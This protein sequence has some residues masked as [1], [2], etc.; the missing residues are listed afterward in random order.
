MKLL[1]KIFLPASLFLFSLSCEESFSPIGDF[2]EKYTLNC[3][4]NGNSGFQEATLTAT[5]FADGK[6]PFTN[7]T[8]PVVKDAIIKIWLNP[9][10][11][12]IMKDST[13][14]DTSLNRYNTPKYFYYIENFKPDFDQ[15]L[16]IEAQLATGQ[17][18]IGTTSTPKQVEFNRRSDSMLPMDNKD[19]VELSWIA[20]EADLYYY[21][22]L[23]FSYEKEIN[24]IR[25]EHVEKI[26]A[27]FI[28]FEGKTIPFYPRASESPAVIFERSAII[29]VLT[30]ISEGIDK[31]SIYLNVQAE[32]EVTVL[33]KNLKSYYQASIDGLDQFTVRLDGSDFTNISGGLGVFG[34]YLKI[35]RTIP[36]S[37]K[38]ITSLGYNAI[39]N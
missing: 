27:R 11:V 16:R 17:R 2:E 39:F 37:E 33:D 28:E 19:I 30:D 32:L 23:T 29:K 8:D 31:G 34:S 22:S 36:I 12:V 9:D 15:E 38:L 26:P 25:T 5:Y 14:S 13:I 1:L 20:K 10:T 24:G 18:L 35:S 6:D 4:L 3:V 7:Q 21:P